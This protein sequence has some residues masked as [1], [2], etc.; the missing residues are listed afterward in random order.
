MIEK[1]KDII[2]R[3]NEALRDLLV[4]LDKQYKSIMK[5]DPMALEAIVDEIKVSNRAVAELE[6]KRREL[7]KGESF[8][9]IIF[10][11]GN[12]ELENSFRETKKIIELL[13][14]QKENNELLIKQ[15]LSF[16]SKMLMILNPDRKA[17]TYNSYG[18]L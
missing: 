18:R 1:L 7:L 12:E 3:E 8:K 5:N 6:V 16:N 4:I 15:Q 9:E 11:S 17:K 14:L 10:K 13:R 2:D